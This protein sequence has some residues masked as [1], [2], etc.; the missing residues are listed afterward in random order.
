MF[1]RVTSPTLPEAPG[2]PPL[3]LMHPTGTCLDEMHDE[4]D[5]TQGEKHLTFYATGWAKPGELTAD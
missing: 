3:V 4:A 5:S 2:G 1:V